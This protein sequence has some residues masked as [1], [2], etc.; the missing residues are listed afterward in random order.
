M[1]VDLSHI[2]ITVLVEVQ[3]V[4]TEVAQAAHLK[5]MFIH[6]TQIVLKI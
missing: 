4:V 3:I 5:D 6:K 1:N 2:V